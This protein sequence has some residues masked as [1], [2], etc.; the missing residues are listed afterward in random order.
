MLAD[1][2]KAFI[3]IM[4]AR[5]IGMNVTG[6]YLTGIFVVIGHDYPIYLKFIGG[7]GIACTLGFLL[8]IEPWMGIE[9]MF[10]WL[11]IALS[12]KYVSLASIVGLL[13]LSLTSILIKP[14]N[15]S[16]SIAFLTVLGIYRH[17]A[18]IKRLFSA[19][20]NKMDILKSLKELFGGN[21]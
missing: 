1:G 14:W 21:K 13:L 16:V 15:F 4:V 8:A 11:L 5:A 9:F 19:N 12:T 17:K 18:N 3:M 7:K 10:I 20:E 6:I 2:S